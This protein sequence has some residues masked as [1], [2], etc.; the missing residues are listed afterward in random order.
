MEQTEIKNKLLDIN[1]DCMSF[2]M[3]LDRYPFGV[4]I[5]LLFRNKIQ[6]NKTKSKRKNQIE[7][8]KNSYFKIKCG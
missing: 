5:F 3:L 8:V 4:F 7:A 6:M 2:F 1:L